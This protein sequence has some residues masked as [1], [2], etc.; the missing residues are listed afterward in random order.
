MKFLEELVIYEPLFA[1]FAGRAAASD[2]QLLPP[3]AAAIQATFKYKYVHTHN[4]NIIML[5]KH[6]GFVFPYIDYPAACL[7]QLK[8]AVF[9]AIPWKDYI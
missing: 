3:G 6:I 8:L 1:V 2:S 7:F 9:D 5:L 4:Y